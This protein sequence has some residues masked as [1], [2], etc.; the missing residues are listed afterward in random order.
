MVLLV[1]Y[2]K[3]IVIFA[4]TI[5]NTQIMRN[6]A[7]INGSRVNYLTMKDLAIKVLK[8]KMREESCYTVSTYMEGWAETMDEIESQDCEGTYT[9]Y[10]VESVLPVAVGTMVNDV[11][12]IKRNVQSHDG[13]DGLHEAL[14][15]IIS[16]IIAFE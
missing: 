6:V 8:I 9:P 15:N 3:K 5:K 13:L 4:E 10:T 11:W 12:T 1:T 16:T 7:V 14:E 2:F